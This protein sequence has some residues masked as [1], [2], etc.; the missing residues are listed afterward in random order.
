MKK[1]SLE[2][3]LLWIHFEILQVLNPA[4]KLF[5]V[6]VNES[7]WCGPVFKQQKIAGRWWVVSSPEGL[8]GSAR[9]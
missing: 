9:G 1:K 4:K 6:G 7:G 2:I 3:C 5:T 8:A